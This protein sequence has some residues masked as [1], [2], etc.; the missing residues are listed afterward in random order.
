MTTGALGFECNEVGS[1]YT[2]LAVQIRG[3]IDIVGTYAS[4][5][6]QIDDGSGHTEMQDVIYNT[7]AHLMSAF[8]VGTLSQLIGQRLVS[9][10]GV[11]EY[12][13]ALAQQKARLSPRATFV[14]LVGY[15]DIDALIS[16][17]TAPVFACAQLATLRCTRVSPAT[18]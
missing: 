7:D 1:S 3:P 16:L 11:V 15:A 14:L 17:P 6:L 12:S 9:I 4:S 10:A 2:G 13:C 5:G 8:G 18:S